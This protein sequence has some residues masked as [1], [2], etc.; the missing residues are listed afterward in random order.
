MITQAELDEFIVAFKE[1]DPAIVNEALEECIKLFGRGD[2]NMMC[3]GSQHEAVWCW[4]AGWKKRDQALFTIPKA[5]WGG[6]WQA[7][8]TVIIPDPRQSEEKIIN[9]VKID[10]IDDLIQAL[11]KFRETHNNLPV[12]CEDDGSQQEIEY[13]IIEPETDDDEILNT[14]LPRRLVIS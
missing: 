13:F 10:S 6:E 8:E 12:F 4:I 2:W 3:S 11:I 7:G 1:E 14:N 9:G 5:G